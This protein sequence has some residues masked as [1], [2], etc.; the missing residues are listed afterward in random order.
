MTNPTEEEKLTLLLR[1]LGA[2]EPAA[3]VM[4]RQLLKRADQMAEERSI[5]RFE[6]LD[7]LLKVTIAGREGRAYEGKPPPKQTTMRD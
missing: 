7:Y 1:N 5:N 2:E 6:A 3:Q 4:A